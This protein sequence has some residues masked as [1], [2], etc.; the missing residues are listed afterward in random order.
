MKIQA[1]V[2]LHHDRMFLSRVRFST[3]LPGWHFNLWSYAVVGCLSFGEPLCGSE[4][5]GT[6]VRM[7]I[8]RESIVKEA[9]S[10]A[11]AA[12]GTAGASVASW[13]QL[14]N[15]FGGTADKHLWS[16]NSCKNW[17]LGIYGLEILDF[18]R[19]LAFCVGWGEAK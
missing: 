7:H 11:A 12:S 4:Q 19:V 18:L 1:C 13:L 14:H 16:G 8:K 2:P 6:K 9:V 3:F 5:V 17:K 10:V 15:I